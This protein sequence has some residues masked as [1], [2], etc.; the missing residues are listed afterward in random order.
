MKIIGI[1]LALICFMLLVLGHAFGHFSVGR[2]LGFKINE[3]SVGMGPLLWSKKKGDLQYSFRAIP[4]GG[5]CAFEG[6]SPDEKDEDGN[7][8]TPDPQSFFLQPA[9]KQIPVLLAGSFNN[10]VIGILIFTIIFTFSGSYSAVL[11]EVVDGA[12]AQKAGIQAGDEIVAIN[13]TY[14]SEWL[15]ITEAIA[16]SEGSTI[17]VTVKRDGKEIEIK[18]IPTYTN[19]QG[20]KVIG[21]VSTIVHSPGKAF[22]TALSECT[23][24]IRALRDF[25][26][27]LFR[28]QASSDE[29]GSIVQIVAVSGEYAEQYGLLTVIYLI[30]LV[31]VNLGFMNL[32][33][34]PGLDGGRI[35]FVLI[36]VITRGKLSAKAE[37]VINNVFMI[38]LL[39]LMVVLMIKDVV[40]L[41][42]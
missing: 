23:T 12:P 42:R 40:W 13:G 19:E 25:F 20:R 28:G 39:G 3:F 15:D 17:D 27:R 9:K 36:R 2:L 11:S 24:M 6:E 14:Y 22:K 4:L 33:P 34:I 7:P 35:L 41:V 18:S 37:A 30:A 21:I 1:V 5:Y 38:L 29:V 16:G 26:V 10:I 31:S 32:L 8:K